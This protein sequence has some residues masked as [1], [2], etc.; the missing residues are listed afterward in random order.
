MFK[1]LV[2]AYYYPPLGLS[3]V[4]RTLKF[5]KYFKDF[6][7]SPTVI[8]TGKIGYFAY[9]ENLLE[10]AK[11]AGIEIIRTEAINPNSILKKKGTVTMPSTW[12][13]KLLGRISK[14]F[15]IPD[16]KKYWAIKAAK[17]AKIELTKNKY[18]AIYISVPPFSSI[19][20]N[21]KA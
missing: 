14:T 12:L 6:N 21:S 15:F 20:P 2:I 19:L 10:E 13:M 7:W 17:V 5:T 18:D 8:T 4:Q 1:V 9:D 11:S 3:G 16:N